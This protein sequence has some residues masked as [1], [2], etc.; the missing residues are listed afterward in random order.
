MPDYT[1]NV[2][3]P[4]QNKFGGDDDIRFYGV[5]VL[6]REEII[7]SLRRGGFDFVVIL[8]E[9]RACSRSMISL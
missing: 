6:M 1:K 2:N 3:L 4:P 5:L 9:R 7:K 8:E